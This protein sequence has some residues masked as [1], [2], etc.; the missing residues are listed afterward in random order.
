MSSMSTTLPLVR[1]LTAPARAN[2]SSVGN[3]SAPAKQKQ[4]TVRI[5]IG[6]N[7]ILEDEL[8]LVAGNNLIVLET[9]HDGWG[10]GM[11][12]FSEQKGAFPLG[13]VEQP[14]DVEW[15]SLIVSLNPPTYEEAVS[16]G[17]HAF[18]PFLSSAAEEYAILK[19]SIMSKYYAQ[20]MID[21]KNI[22]IES[23][24]SKITS[25]ESCLEF[26][27]TEILSAKSDLDKAKNP[28]Q[29]SALALESS[30][31]QM[32]VTHFKQTL[33]QL[34]KSRSHIQN[35][36]LKCDLQHSKMIEE[37]KIL[38]DALVEL[39]DLREQLD[40]LIRRTFL[41]DKNEVNAAPQIFAKDLIKWKIVGQFENQLDEANFKRSLFKETKELLV[42]ANAHLHAALH[43]WEVAYEA[44][45]SNDSSTMKEESKKAIEEVAEAISLITIAKKT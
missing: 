7:A 2:S 23:I 21:S 8:D 27:D 22:A 26:I 12:P 44:N 18:P 10:I 40:C 16:L 6:Y 30:K 43:S 24:K 33:S 38:T 28:P 20:D 29:E 36:I 17:S 45:F 32:D 3:S 35:V 37:L 4:L 13:C 25:F 42:V 15:A 9:F 11:H 5:L 41:G 34:Q 19:N 1:A 14:D 31:S 39:E